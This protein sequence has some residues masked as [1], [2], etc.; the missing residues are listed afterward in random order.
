MPRWASGLASGVTE[1]NGR[2]Y[3]ASPMGR[4]E[5]EMVRR[6]SFGVLDHDVITSDGIRT[7]NALRVT[8]AGNGAVLTFTLLRSPTG[9]A[10]DFDKDAD[11][12]AHDLRALK[13]LL[14]SR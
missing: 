5:I 11:T 6:N 10:D 8:P 12:V 1:E 3:A 13:R 14:E 9:T 7:H 4:V 2:W